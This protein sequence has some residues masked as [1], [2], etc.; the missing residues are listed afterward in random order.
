[1]HT[2]CSFFAYLFIILLL[3]V[4]EA[5]HLLF[6]F[7]FFYFSHEIGMVVLT[8]KYGEGVFIMLTVI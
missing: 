8:V 6:G 1:M 2:K 3:R 5:F 7:V 4:G